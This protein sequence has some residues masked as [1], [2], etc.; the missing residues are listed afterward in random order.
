MRSRPR[1]LVGV[2]LHA[3][4]PVT[5]PTGGFAPVHRGANGDPRGSS[6][7]DLAAEFLGDY[8]YSG[9]T[10]GYGAGVWNDMPNGADCAAIDAYRQALHDEAPDVQRECPA[11]FGNLGHLRRLLHG[12]RLPRNGGGGVRAAPPPSWL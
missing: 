11:T 10:N 5:G 1:N 7:N 3:D 2:V 9:A 12:S 6:E 8:V 4:A